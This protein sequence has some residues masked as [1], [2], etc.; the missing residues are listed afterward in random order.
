MP[1]SGDIIHIIQNPDKSENHKEKNNQLNRVAH[2]PWP[3]FA[4]NDLRV[5]HVM[6]FRPGLGPT[7][8][9]FGPRKGLHSPGGIPAG[10]FLAK[11]V[12]P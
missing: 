1:S 2:G 9:E 6:S 4:A 11:V 3:L 5:R 8:S 7:T 10:Q 12:L